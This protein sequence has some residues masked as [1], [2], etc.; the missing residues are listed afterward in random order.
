MNQKLFI[1][2]IGLCWLFSYIPVFAQ[3]KLD[4]DQFIPD[5]RLIYSNER[6]KLIDIYPT[7]SGV[8]LSSLDFSNR[9]KKELKKQLVDTFIT[10]DT[11]NLPIDTLQVPC[12]P[13][14]Y[15]CK[16]G[17][18]FL[19]H[20]SM[21]YTTVY[22]VLDGRKNKY[23][24]QLDLIFTVDEQGYFQNIRVHK[25]NKYGKIKTTIS[26][27]KNK[28]YTANIQEYTV[29]YQQKEIPYYPFV[30]GLLDE[31]QEFLID[32]VAG[33]IYLLKGGE[34]LTYP[35]PEAITKDNFIELEY[36]AIQKAYYL[37]QEKETHLGVYRL[38]NKSFQLLEV[39][40]R[41][42]YHNTIIDGCLYSVL[43]F[44]ESQI[45][46]FFK[47]RKRLGQVL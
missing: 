37:L 46:G 3:D 2:I 17:G 32:F 41:Q 9:T 25:E 44:S 12:W 18:Q 8:L 36:D 4:V 22:N 40:P 26:G 45:E 24:D 16:A 42:S 10:L 31:G 19:Y 30:K 7:T 39:S 6:L 28:V 47:Y 38:E 13:S 14:E 20:P 15:F 27:R 33:R 43:P 1:L 35:L 11:R 29:E 23:T 5:Y 21:L 34:C